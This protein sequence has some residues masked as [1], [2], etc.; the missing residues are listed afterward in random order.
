MGLPGYWSM[1]SWTT[2]PQ[3]DIGQRLRRNIVRYLSMRDYR[4][5]A[6]PATYDAFL[7]ST[8]F[9]SNPSPPSLHPDPILPHHTPRSQTTTTL[10]WFRVSRSW[11]TH[12]ASSPMV[13]CCPLKIMQRCSYKSTFTPP[14]CFHRNHLPSRGR[15]D[16][17]VPLTS[18]FPF[19]VVLSTRLP[20]WSKSRTS[21]QCSR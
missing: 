5:R 10:L 6:S 11:P 12:R 15:Q 16:S 17:T 13:F 18:L 19:Y 3:Q 9:L 14:A 2:T 8:H 20:Q 7:P 1:L 21:D 4:V